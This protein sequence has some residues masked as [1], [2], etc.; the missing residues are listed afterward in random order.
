MI[1]NALRLLCSAVGAL[2]LF[3]MASWILVFYHYFPN[4]PKFVALGSF[5]PYGFILFVLPLMFMFWILGNKKT[6]VISLLLFFMFF[7]SF[8][9]FSFKSKGT[10]QH[11][12]QSTNGHKLSVIALNVRYYSY[13]LKKVIKAIKE[14]DADLYLISENVLSTEEQQTLEKEL[15]PWTFHMGRQEGTAIIS[16]FPIVDFKEVVL[17][18]K[19]ASLSKPN[20][21]ERQHLNPNRSFVHATVNVDGTPVH[22]ISIRFLAGRSASRRL[23]DVYN[24]GVY[25][26]GM[27]SKELGFFLNYLNELKGPIIFGGDLNAT[28]S[29][30]IVRRLSEIAVDSYLEKHFWG[31]FTF[32]TQF[33]SYARLDYI[34]SMNGV[35][36]LSSEILDVVVSDHYPVHS[37]FMIPENKI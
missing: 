28:P 9:D 34:F 16:R 21:V 8:G 18:S 19:Q 25:V 23:S 17:P 12:D 37:Q 35:R 1:K 5:P 26:F 3:T 22:A 7:I 24:W 32:W 13:E 31:G 29:S 2:V 11:S 33:P 30:M 27:Q 14:M 6:A 10:S 4:E 20:E 15:Y 36:V